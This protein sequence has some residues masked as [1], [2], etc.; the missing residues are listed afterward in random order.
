MR[1]GVKIE[2]DGCHP[3]IVIR[4][5]E[6]LQSEKRPEIQVTRTFAAAD[7]LNFSLQPRLSTPGLQFW[8]P[9]SA[10]QFVLELLEAVPE[11]RADPDLS[12]PN[13]GVTVLR[14]SKIEASNQ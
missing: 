12:S 11:L 1:A 6:R 10:F 7:R 13:E 3:A 2:R 14:V 5:G 4:V 9:L 8:F